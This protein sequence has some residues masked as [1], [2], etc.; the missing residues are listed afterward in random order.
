MSQLADTF[1]EKTPLFTL[2]PAT[3]GPSKLDGIFENW[4]KETLEQLN[5]AQDA[6]DQLMN[7]MN[8]RFAAATRIQDIDRYLK[9]FVDI[10]Q[11]KLVNP[12][13]GSSA[14]KKFS[15]QQSPIVVEKYKSRTFPA[16][17][18]QNEELHLIFLRAVLLMNQAFEDDEAGRPEAAVQALRQSAGIFQ[19]L[20]SDKCRNIDATTLP[21]EFQAPVL[22]SLMNLALGQVY[23]IIASKGER[24]GTGK[25]ALAKVC[26][27]ASTTFQT[28]FDAIKA[29][30]P[31]DAFHRQYSDW[32]EQMAALYHA[33]SCALFALAQKQ[34]EEDGMAIGLIRLAIK[35]A[36]KV[37]N[38]YPK[39][40][41][42]NAAIDEL[43]K[44]LEPIDKKWS[45]ENFIIA[46]KPI[47]DEN[48]ANR[49]IAT[50][51]LV[52]LNLPQ[53]TPYTAPEA[54]GSS[55]GGYGGEQK[56]VKKITPST[57]YPD[58]E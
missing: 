28:A 6:R 13:I 9:L 50:S 17:Y 15:W 51:A 1:L 42:P 25:S 52:L 10:E 7:H 44:K 16:T 43:I 39:N 22:N 14:S 41:R 27:T 3:L 23:A 48:A 34:K 47:A 46:C 53:P 2:T 55:A 5:A 40:A 12:R 32:I 29:A 8:G 58:S 20:A 37:Q 4:P 33:Y 49:F 21:I 31:A 56:V 38:L 24:D 30:T 11:E 26:Y 45:E 36:K 54:G 19:Y 35:E 18:C 57:R